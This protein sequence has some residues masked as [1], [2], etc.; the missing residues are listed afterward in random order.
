MK[1]L[2]NVMEKFLGIDHYFFQKSIEIRGS[3]YLKTG[4]PWGVK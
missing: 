4:F 3:F 1:T 2:K